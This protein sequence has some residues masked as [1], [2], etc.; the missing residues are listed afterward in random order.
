MYIGFEYG[1][2]RAFGLW[3]TAAG[4]HL[5]HAEVNATPNMVAGLKELQ[6]NLNLDFDHWLSRLGERIRRHGDQEQ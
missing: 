3:I 1:R 2:A 4:F 5:S 6:F